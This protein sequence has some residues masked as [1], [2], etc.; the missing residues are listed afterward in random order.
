MHR[1]EENVVT[2]PVARIL[3]VDDE[4]E[5]IDLIRLYLEREQF[6]VHAATNGDDAIR[7]VEQLKPDLVILDILLGN[8][9]GIEVCRTLRAGAFPE[10]PILFLSAK[11]EDNDIVAGLSHG[12]DDYMTKPFSPSQLVARVH[13]HIRRRRMNE[14]LYREPSE[15]LR[16]PG[17]E[18]DLQQ[19]EVRRGDERVALSVKEFELLTMLARHPNRIFSLDELYRLVWQTDSIGDTRTLMVHISNLRKKIESNP[20]RPQ[21]IQTVRGFGYR[22]DPEG[23]IIT[24][25]RTNT[26]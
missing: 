19:V 18:I 12:G 7:M 23:G 4:M 14:K 8:P 13:A 11:S 2:M 1:M 24:D 20:S 16:F 25:A 15:I 3:V 26:L 22:F 9:D 6:A 5:I 17:L 10:V 21:W